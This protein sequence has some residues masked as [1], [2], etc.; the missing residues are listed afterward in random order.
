MDAHVEALY[1]RIYTDSVVDSTEAAQLS[2]F[3][4]SLNPPPDKLL[5]LRST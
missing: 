3:F 5:W 2:A 4:D 1:R